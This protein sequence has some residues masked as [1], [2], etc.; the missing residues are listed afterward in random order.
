M[1]IQGKEHISHLI[2]NHN[3]MHNKTR[4][5]TKHSE[6]INAATRLLDLHK[7]DTTVCIQSSGLTTSHR[8]HLTHEWAA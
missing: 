4:N 8:P 5:T 6:S 2:K 7:D 1:Y 3:T